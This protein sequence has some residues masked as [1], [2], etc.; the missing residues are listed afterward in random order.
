MTDKFEDM[1]DLKRTRKTHLARMDMYA[2][3]AGKA[4]T[5][6]ERFGIKRVSGEP[7]ED[8]RRMAV[9]MMFQIRDTLGTDRL[10]ISD[11]LAIVP[12]YYGTYRP[13]EDEND[14]EIVL[15]KTEPNLHFGNPSAIRS[16][17][18]TYVIAMELV[19]RDFRNYEAYYQPLARGNERYL[20]HPCN[21]PLPPVEPNDK[22]RVFDIPIGYISHLSFDEVSR[23]IKLSVTGQN[24]E[25]IH[26]DI[27][28]PRRPVQYDKKGE[29]Y[30]QRKIERVKIKDDISNKKAEV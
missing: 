27:E 18:M 23:T 7:C 3:N 2:Y 14:K 24:G 21:S 17:T 19:I 10:V 6:F 15:S 11:R 8:L 25:L 9:T 28:M 22:A 5:A 13:P 1:P 16:G 26:I 12:N 30:V 29:P 20:R 4:V